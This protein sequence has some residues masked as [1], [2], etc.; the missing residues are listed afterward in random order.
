MPGAK[1]GPLFE[2]PP[3][4]LLKSG[5]FRSPM[6]GS[7]NGKYKG[8]SVKYA[9]LINSVLTLDKSIHCCMIVKDNCK[10]QLT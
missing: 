8:V 10:G 3:R 7:M 9:S 4:P 2:S 6:L 1:T 5:L